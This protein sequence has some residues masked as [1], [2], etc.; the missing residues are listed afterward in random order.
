MTVLAGA[1]AYP[2]SAGAQ[3]KAMPVI[4]I[5]SLNSPG[6]NAPNV[7]SFR[8]GFRQGLGET[9]W[10]EGQ[11][12]VIEFLGAEGLLIGCPHWPTISSAAKSM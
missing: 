8:Q 7:A 10:V 3:Q 12:V 6:P 1:A 5:L 11:N 2:L 4:G 9:G